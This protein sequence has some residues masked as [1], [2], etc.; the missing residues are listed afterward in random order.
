MK[1]IAFAV[2]VLAGALPLYARHSHQWRQAVVEPVSLKVVELPDG[3][4][5]ATRLSEQVR[6]GSAQIRSGVGTSAIMNNSSTRSVIIP[7]AGSVRGGGGTFFRSDITLVNWNQTAQ[8]VA[9]VWMPNGG[10]STTFRTTF[11]G[12]RPPFTVQDFVGTLLNRDG[13]GSLFF[14]PITSAGAV[15]PNGAIDAYSRIWTPQPNATGTVS[16]PFPGVDPNHL[17]GEYEAFVLGL[18]QDSAYRT[19]FGIVNL[20]NTQLNFL[21]T[22]FPESAAPGALT[23]V[24]VTIPAMSMIQQALPAGAYATPINLLV[25]VDQNVSG[26]NQVWTAYASS[27]DNITGDG[28]VSIAGKDWDDESLDSAAFP[29]LP[30]KDH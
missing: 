18:R 16:Q 22:V 29:S 10:A 5:V 20:Y 12:D 8:D 24:H 1:R 23:E 3:A 2:A 19:N 25:E 11:P 17:K 4:A 28:W 13:L 9:V 7:A 6:A 21:V 26:S 30:R 27:T 15:D 14:I